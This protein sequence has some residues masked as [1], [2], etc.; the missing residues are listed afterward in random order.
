MSVNSLT[1]YYKSSFPNWCNFALQVEK[2][3][4]LEKRINIFKFSKVFQ[5]LRENIKLMLS[6]PKGKIS[7]K[8]RLLFFLVSH[9]L[10]NLPEKVTWVNQ[11]IPS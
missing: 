2:S 6:V 5:E 11:L 1:S 10:A 3:C 4:T 9:I 7:Q 8:I